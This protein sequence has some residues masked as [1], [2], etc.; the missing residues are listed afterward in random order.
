MI[1][2]DTLK[3]LSLCL[4]DRMHIIGMFDNEHNLKEAMLFI[5]N[6]YLGGSFLKEGEKLPRYRIHVTEI[7][8]NSI[9]IPSR[10]NDISMEGDS[11]SAMK[12]EYR[13]SPIPK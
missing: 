2:T 3:I 7:M 11:L 4:E 13:K 8:V 6:I 9:N 1:L 5:N 12:R 10:D